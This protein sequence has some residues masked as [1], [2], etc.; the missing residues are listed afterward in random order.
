M[1]VL[2]LILLPCL[3]LCRIGGSTHL[4]PTAPRPVELGDSP[5]SPADTPLLLRI[6]SQSGPKSPHQIE[7]LTEPG[8]IFPLDI[9]IPCPALYPRQP[10][11]L[12]ISGSPSPLLSPTSRF[13]APPFHSWPSFNPA[14][15]V[16]SVQPLQICPGAVLRTLP[17]A[18]LV[19]FD[20]KCRD[21]SRNPDG[22]N[23]KF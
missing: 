18:L 17:Q 8:C 19:L 2:P 21:K 23:L 9:S 22:Q 11:S 4:R 3:L 7:P 14:S 13:P 1:G 6:S 10:P 16:T 15:P 20:V 5:A 12:P